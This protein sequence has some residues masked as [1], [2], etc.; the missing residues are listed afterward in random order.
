MA[1]AVTTTPESL[2]TLYTVL[3]IALIPIG[4]LLC[5]VLIRLFLILN[6]LGD[7]LSHARYELYPVIKDARSLTG[8]IDRVTQR[9][10]DYMDQLE[11]GAARTGKFVSEKISKVSKLAKPASV[12]LGSLIGIAVKAL[13]KK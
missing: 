13:L 6:D 4:L 2:T 3:W 1:I 12:G 5:C 10:E 8:R 7:F 11:S 9:A